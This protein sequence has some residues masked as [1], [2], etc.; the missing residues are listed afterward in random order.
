MRLLLPPEVAGRMATAL[1]EAGRR[2]IGGILMGEH[3]GPDMFR[4]KELT[5]QRKGGTFATFV[6]VVQSIVGPLQAFFR[7]TRHDY[8]RFNYLGEWHSHHSFAL[9]PSTK[10]HRSMFDI[11]DDPQLG[12]NFVVLLL[13]K[14]NQTALDCAVFIYQPNAQPHV[15]EVVLQQPVTP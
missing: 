11:I 9:K 15:G 1:S 3:V 8:T 4:V 13:V 12:A 7:A 2:E 10:D 6:R 14:L 5:I